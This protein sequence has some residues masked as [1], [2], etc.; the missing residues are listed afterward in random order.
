MKHG[1]LLQIDWLQKAQLLR[2]HHLRHSF[3]YTFGAAEELVLQLFFVL[4][5][6]RTFVPNGKQKHAVVNAN[7]CSGHEEAL[8]REA[9]AHLCGHLRGRKHLPDQKRQNSVA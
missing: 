9:V 7:E 4:A 8:W 3:H 5:A 1:Q 6:L 2:L